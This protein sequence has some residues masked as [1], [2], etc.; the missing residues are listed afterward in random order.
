MKYKI[1]VW[2]WQFAGTAVPIDIILANVADE[3]YCYKCE[4]CTGAGQPVHLHRVFKICSVFVF[5]H[6]KKPAD[7][8][9]EHRYK[10]DLQ[11]KE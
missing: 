7:K 5:Y 4:A 3:N 9:Y 2:E 10:K 8:I 1:S 11:Q 6:G